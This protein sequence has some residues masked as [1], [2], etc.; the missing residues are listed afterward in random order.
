MF[1]INLKI[2][3]LKLSVSRSKEQGKTYSCI[4][5][6]LFTLNIVICMYMCISIFELKYHDQESVGEYRAGL[7]SITNIVYLHINSVEFYAAVTNYDSF[8]VHR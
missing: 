5:N 3:I 4:P 7:Q 6:L 2:Y 8:I 1:L